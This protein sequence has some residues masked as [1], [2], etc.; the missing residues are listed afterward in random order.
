M[1]RMRAG[2]AMTAGVPN[3]AMVSRNTTIAPPRIA[4]VTSG[5]VM[6]KTV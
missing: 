3:S 1:M 5:K 6:R 4:G 2:N